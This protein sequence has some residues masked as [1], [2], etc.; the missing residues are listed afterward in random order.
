MKRR[1]FNLL[2]GTSLAGLGLAGASGTTAR[3][4][5]ASLL[6]TTLTPFGAERAGNAAGTIPAW[7]GGMTANSG[8]HSLGSGSPAAA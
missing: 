2:A 3:A 8:G 4:A 6:Q 5:D 7:T 1:N